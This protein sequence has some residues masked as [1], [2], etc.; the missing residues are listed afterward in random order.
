MHIKRL[1]TGRWQARYRDSEKR[2]HA[3]NFRTRIEAQRWLDTVTA[4]MVRS[5]YVDPRAG[6]AMIGELAERWYAGT[7]TLKPSTRANYRSLLDA[8]VLPRWANIELRNVS[9]SAIKAW[10][11]D[12]SASS[13]ASTT[14][15]ALG[16][17]RNTLDLAVADRRL[18]VNPAAGVA[19]PK[20]PITEQRFLQADELDVL[21]IATGSERDRVLV[22]V[23]GWI[24]LRFG[25][26]VALQ[27][28]DVDTL[29]RRI[30]ISRSATEVR[31]RIEW[32]T[33]KSHT[34]RTV[35]VP[36]FLTN[37]IAGLMV[38]RESL[39]FRDAQGGPIRGTNWKHR[40]FDSAAR[41]VG[42][43]PPPL[44]VHDLRH[45]AASLAIRAGGSIKS[46]QMQLGHQSATLTLDRYG[47]LFPDE[48]GALSTALE[49]LRSD[50]V[51][52]SLRTVGEVADVVELPAGR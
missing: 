25:E 19:Q 29:R 42:L 14:R 38:D 47:H 17:L 27:A 33:P 2:E 41:E 9:T 12:L 20:L 52:D 28:G 22:L 30:R 4:S 31:G 34:A 50:S 1:E 10:V 5:D 35:A 48:L 6:K 36:A 44:R 26:A 51:A 40:V 18:A 39:V 7:A 49:K 45:T 21:A 16:V 32:G 24:G 3:R 8:H 37:D 23:L 13:A 11:S 43:T 46:L 15:K